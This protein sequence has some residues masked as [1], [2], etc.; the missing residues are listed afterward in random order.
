MVCGVAATC[1]KR[2]AL[3]D[4][5]APGALNELLLS[6]SF[7]ESESASFGESGSILVAEPQAVHDA[8]YLPVAWLCVS[9]PS[10]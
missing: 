1:P 4:Y 3:P 5:D 2:L 7:R 9:S 10:N 6:L 8:T